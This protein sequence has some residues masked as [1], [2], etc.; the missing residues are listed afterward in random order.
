MSFHRARRLETRPPWSVHPVYRSLL[1]SGHCLVERSQRFSSSCDSSYS[2]SANCRG[3][4]DP[5]R[6]GREGSVRCGRTRSGVRRAVGR[7]R[8]H[9]FVIHI[10]FCIVSFI[11]LI[12]IFVLSLLMPLMVCLSGPFFL[13][14]FLSFYKKQIQAGKKTRRRRQRS[15]RR[16]RLCQ[17]RKT[18]IND[19]SLTRTSQARHSD[20]SCLRVWG[21]GFRV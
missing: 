5:G 12:D 18:G 21:L 15:K 20:S 7:P 9:S 8:A 13:H 6:T 19:S 17:H 11:I 3:L 10:K 2:S 16:R 4:M 1:L 14:V